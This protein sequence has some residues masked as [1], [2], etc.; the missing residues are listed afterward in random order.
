M[1]IWDVKHYKA[2]FLALASVR[3]GEIRTNKVWR[4]KNNHFS[5]FYRFPLGCSIW[6]Y[7]CGGQTATPTT[8]SSCVAPDNTE[9]E[10]LLVLAT[11]GRFWVRGPS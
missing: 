11:H 6:L 5:I 1:E 4:E 9:E 8:G 2:L 3:N 7:C 10:M